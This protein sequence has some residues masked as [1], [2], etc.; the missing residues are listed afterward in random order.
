MWDLSATTSMRSPSFAPVRSRIPVTASGE[1]NL[2]M[3]PLTS[4]R[5]SIDRWAR[6]FAPNRFARR[7][8]VDQLHAEADVWLFGAEPLDDL[9]VRE[10]G[11][12]HLQE[13]PLRCGRRA[14]L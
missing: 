9:V 10:H 8:E 14:D 1:R 11:E 3:C 5:P 6:P 12:R 7:G 13:R 2:A 4:P